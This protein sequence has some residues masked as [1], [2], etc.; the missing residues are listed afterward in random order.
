[1]KTRNLTE[2]LLLS[3]CAFIIIS[4]ADKEDS[5]Q[6]PDTPNDIYINPSVPAGRIFPVATSSRPLPFL[7]AGYDIMGSYIDNESVKL[8]VLDLDKIDT[9]LIARKVPNSGER[10]DFRGRDVR[11]FLRSINEFKEFVV[12]S[13]NKDDLLFAGTITDHSQFNEPYD[14]SSQYTFVYESSGGKMLTEDLLTLNAK[15]SSW[16]SDEFLLDMEELT[17][18]ALVETYGTHVLVTTHLGYMVKTLYR[19]VV[20]DDERNSR[21]FLKTAEAGMG[22]RKSTIIKYPNITI[23][24]PEEAVKKNYGGAIV[25][26]F[27][28]AD[29]KSMPNVPISGKDPSVVIGD[30]VT[31][32]SWAQTANEKNHALVTLSGKDLIPIYEVITDPIKKKQIKEAVIAYIKARQ[33]PSLQTAPILQASDGTYHRYY[34]SY[35]ELTDKKDICQGVIGSVFVRREPG[36]VPLYLSSHKENHRLSL[37]PAEDAI[38]IGYVYQE[39]SDDLDRVF[40]I[41]DGKSFSYTREQ[42]DSYGEKG[43]WKPTGKYFYTK[44]V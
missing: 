22:A 29:S 33:L 17:P 3:L 16:L 15:W 37:T 30:P 42:K 9:E 31:I 21:D 24:Y 38:T 28:G 18:E 25:I 5:S 11:E 39:N 23:D 26:T 4:C 2:K 35:T 27:Q 14:Y 13:E 36:T 40:E 41:S 8:P 10:N 1:M 7:G 44:K 43:T 6:F 20:A 34:T 32:T 12:P 19:S